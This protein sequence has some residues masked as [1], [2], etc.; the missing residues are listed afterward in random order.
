MVKFPYFAKAMVKNN[1]LSRFSFHKSFDITHWNLKF[2]PF[3][4]TFSLKIE[5]APKRNNQS[6]K[7]CALT[8]TNIRLQI[9]LIYFNLWNTSS[10]LI[11][12][13]FQKHPLTFKPLFP[14]S[15]S[16]P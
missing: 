10:S 12:N 15:T 7:C 11:S 8:R 6:P 14:H 2:Q 3:P 9:Y 16:F 1:K 4:K 5:H 13:L